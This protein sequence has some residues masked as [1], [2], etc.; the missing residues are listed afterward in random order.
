MHHVAC[1][2]SGAYPYRPLTASVRCDHWLM[3]LIGMAAITLA[4]CLVC[5][6]Q[7]S[8]SALGQMLSASLLPLSGGKNFQTKLPLKD[9]LCCLDTSCNS[10][11]LVSICVYM[12]HCVAQVSENEDGRAVETAGACL[13]RPVEE[14]RGSFCPAYPGGLHLGSGHL[15][16][17]LCDLSLPNMLSICMWEMETG[18]ERLQ[19]AAKD[20]DPHALIHVVSC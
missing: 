12:W 20:S 10:P 17:G 5:A 15:L 11:R 18:L 7:P 3:W 19:Q 2:H 13:P 14:G 9:C 6:D 4:L 16:V 8:S 1:L